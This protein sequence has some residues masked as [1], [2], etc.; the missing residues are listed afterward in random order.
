MRRRHPM[1][2]FALTDRRLAHVPSAAA[3]R[4]AGIGSV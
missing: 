4:S 1:A 3:D 2:R